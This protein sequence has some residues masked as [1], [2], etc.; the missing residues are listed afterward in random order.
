[1]ALLACSQGQLV[2]LNAVAEAPLCFALPGVQPLVPLVERE[3]ILR[4]GSLQADG[5][6]E[7]AGIED[8]LRLEPE[9]LHQPAEEV[10]LH[11]PRV[12]TPEVM[13]NDPQAFLLSLQTD[14]VE[15]AERI[16]N[17]HA[18]FLH[19]A[20][21]DELRLKALLLQSCFRLF[22]SLTQPLLIDTQLGIRPV[23]NNTVLVQNLPVTNVAPAG[24]DQEGAIVL[25]VLASSLHV[26]DEVLIRDASQILQGPLQP[27]GIH[28]VSRLRTL[29]QNG[30]GC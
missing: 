26:N 20:I 27:R 25:C 24:L 3:S 15:F 9:A 14:L 28:A 22:Q 30:R 8:V 6:L 17:I 16:H 18:I 29:F 21:G 19:F 2:L 13:A 7:H 1:M 23:E 10:P 12:G 4:N 5:L 11:D